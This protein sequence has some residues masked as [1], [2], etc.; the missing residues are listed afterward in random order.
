MTDHIYDVSF[1]RNKVNITPF[2]KEPIYQTN[3]YIILRTQYPQYFIKVYITDDFKKNSQLANGFSKATSI[4]SKNS[5]NVV[6]ILEFQEIVPNIAILIESYQFNLEELIDNNFFTTHMDVLKFAYQ[7]ALNIDLMWEAKIDGC[8]I[9]SESVVIDS[10]LNYKVTHFDIHPIELDEGEIDTI[11]KNRP[12]VAPELAKKDT[13]DHFS[14]VWELGSLLYRIVTSEMPVFNE[15]G[16]LQENEKLNEVNE[17]LIK[18]IKGCLNP[19]KE[20]RILVEKILESVVAFNSRSL[21]F[22]LHTNDNNDLINVFLDYNLVPTQNN[23]KDLNLLSYRPNLKRKHDVYE[24]LH[25]LYDPKYMINNDLLRELIKMG[26]GDPRNHVYTYQKTLSVAKKNINNKTI[27][28]KILLI[29]HSYLHKS[30]KKSLIIFHVDNKSKNYYEDIVAQIYTA[31]KNNNDRFLAGYAGTIQA[32][33]KTIFKNIKSINSNFSVTKV[34]IISRWAVLLTPDLFFSLYE[35]L[36]ILMA[37]FLT[38]KDYKTNYFTKNVVLLICTEISCLMGLIVNLLVLLKYLI[39]YNED[40]QD[41]SLIDNFI[42]YVIDI[43]ENHRV[44]FDNYLNELSNIEPSFDLHSLFKIE[45]NLSNGYALLTKYMKSRKEKKVDSKGRPVFTM[46]DYT[47]YFMN[48]LI[49]MP[50]AHNNL[51][52]TSVLNL[53]SNSNYLSDIAAIVTSFNSRLDSLKLNKITILKVLPLTPAMDRELVETSLKIMVNSPDDDKMIKVSNRD[54]EDEINDEEEEETIDPVS[55]RNKLKPYD[56]TDN[57]VEEEKVMIDVGLQNK[58]LEE[59]KQNLELKK[60]LLEAEIEELNNKE[61]DKK[62]ESN[63]ENEGDG[64]IKELTADNFSTAAIEKFI[65]DEFT[66]SSKEWLITFDKLVIEDEISTGTHFTVFKGLYKNQPS[67]I[68]RFTVSE[69]NR[70]YMK[71]LKREISVLAS[72]PAHSSLVALFG[73]CVHEEHVY[74]VVDYCEGGSMFDLLNKEEPSELT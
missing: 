58:V 73:I 13:Y 23:F 7:M 34:D 29:L 33:F 56:L 19:V 3:Q 63:E 55:V 71:D 51:G 65:I 30:S 54:L 2:G 45:K 41:S 22:I 4:L 67:A 8:F 64:D 39:N 40:D 74:V 28:M 35:Y 47:R 31:A 59:E 53:D 17:A 42:E 21:D 49:R 72:L 18:I 6:N 5:Q 36:E 69:K 43:C 61:E 10:L 57:L 44:V 62:E 48:Y 1:T 38:V 60:E 37:F 46:K 12:T 15:E 27:I 52:Q 24:I 26:W 11:I 66:A 14:N 16:V 32:K 20:E 9:S 25:Y 68:K 70:K 50:E